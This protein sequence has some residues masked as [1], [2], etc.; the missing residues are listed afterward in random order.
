MTTPLR[1]TGLKAALLLGVALCAW[2]G[3][4]PEPA[5]STP[6]LASTESALRLEFATWAPRVLDGQLPFE[7]QDESFVS[8]FQSHGLRLTLPK[9]ARRPFRLELEGLA[10]AVTESGL[11]GE[12]GLTGAAVAYR[13]TAGTSFWSATDE[14]VEEWLHL[15][16]GVATGRGPVATWT[17]TGAT[18][19]QQGEAIELSG[20][21]GVARLRVTAPLAW[22]EGD[23]QVPAILKTRGSVIELWVDAGGAAVLVD[24][25]WV[26]TTSMAAGRVAHT[27]NA[28]PDGQVLVTGG[29]TGSAVLSSAEIFESGNAHLARGRPDEHPTREPPGDAPR[30][31]QGAGVRRRQRGGRARQR[32]ALRPGDEHLGP[33]ASAG[34]GPLPTHG[35]TPTERQGA[36]GGWLLGFRRARRRLRCTTR[37]RT[38]GALSPPPWSCATGTARPCSRT[39]RC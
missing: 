4:Q 13:R 28:L 19:S 6:T 12:G 16:R 38:P 27:Q 25:A 32:G 23:R 30:Q 15:E 31:W 8:P 33:R 22:A 18:L 21:D 3:C 7:D 14:G 29:Y 34:P 11:S 36:G 10:V 5:T 26:P 9:A 37:S 2:F 1:R 35:D 17:V 39:A 20:E 24:P